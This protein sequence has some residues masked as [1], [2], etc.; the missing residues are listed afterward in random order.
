[1]SILTLL[2]CLGGVKE[3]RNGKYIARCPAHDD[4]S[5]SLSITECD[6]GRVLLHCFAGC[7]T[8]DVLR[9]VGLTFHDVMPEPLPQRYNSSGN[10]APYKPLRTPFDARQVLATLDHESLVIAVIGADIAEN[11]EIGEPTWKRLTEAVQRI[12][13]ARAVAAPLR[14]RR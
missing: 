11:R 2:S 7:E 10:P 14:V 9:A 3:S 5:P 1:M 13:S 4:S 6:D 12:N 8:E